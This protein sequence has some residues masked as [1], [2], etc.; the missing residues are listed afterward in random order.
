MDPRG[1][2]VAEDRHVGVHPGEALAEVCEESHARHDIRSEI[3]KAESIG[4]HDVL[5]EIREGGTEPAGEVV[6]KEGV[7]IWGGLDVG[8]DEARGWMPRLLS[9]CLHPPR[10]FEELLELGH[11]DRRGEVGELR[12]SCHRLALRLLHCPGIF[13]HSLAYGGFGRH[14]GWESK[15]QKTAETQ[16]R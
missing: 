16:R 6:D 10:I 8:R 7:P 1:E 11:V 5:E 3:Q 4:V 2:V 9:S 13:G 14:G 12:P 15:R